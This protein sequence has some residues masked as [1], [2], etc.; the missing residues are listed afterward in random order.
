[1]PAWLVA[2]EERGSPGT[3]FK[4]NNFSFG[5]TYV[6]GRELDLN[7]HRVGGGRGSMK[8]KIALLPGA[9]NL[10]GNRF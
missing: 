6:L 3:E 9:K 5:G 2:T 1:M 10:G 4:N 8:P 7:K